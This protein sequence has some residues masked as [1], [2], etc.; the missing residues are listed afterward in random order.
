MGICFQ[1]CYHVGHIHIFPEK[2]IPTNVVTQEETI[3]SFF[4]EIGY[5]GIPWYTPIIWDYIQHTINQGL[6]NVI[7]LGYWTPPFNGHYR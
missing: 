4:Y 2:Q 6:V 5:T 1:S 3:P 7:F